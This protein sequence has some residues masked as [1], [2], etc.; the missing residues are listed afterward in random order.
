MPLVV[1]IC[2]LSNGRI[3]ILCIAVGLLVIM[4][5]FKRQQPGKG[6]RAMH[7]SHGPMR[8]FQQ[9][10]TE[11]PQLLPGITPSTPGPVKVIILGYFRTGSTLVG[12]MLQQNPETFY[13]FEPLFTLYERNMVNGTAVQYVNGTRRVAPV[14]GKEIPFVLHTLHSILNCDVGNL[15]LGTLHKFAK[16]S[17]SL[18]KCYKCFPS[19][20]TPNMTC[21]AKLK[22]RCMSSS[23]R[24]I[25]TIRVSMET[26]EVL[27]KQDP[28]VKIIHLLRD[29]R[30]HIHGWLAHSRRERAQLRNV[31]INGVCNRIVN[32]INKMKSLKERYPQ[33]FTELIYEDFIHYPLEVSK[34]LHMFLNVPFNDMLI[35]WLHTVI[36]TGNGSNSVMSIVKNNSVDTAYEWTKM[37]WDTV[38]LVNTHCRDII[39]HGKFP[40]IGSPDEYRRFHPALKSRPVI[41]KSSWIT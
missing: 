4:G 35:D 31:F 7:D 22:A 10:M 5:V 16:Y 39:S 19:S 17:K 9:T 28:D 34:N 20:H 26:I 30:G 1:R 27:M 18:T 14:T 36:S 37:P 6:P 32:D 25:K 29:P 3:R 33:Q 13:M 24:V 11:P 21:L 23:L 15:E 40:L 41:L 38:K 12:E 8:N 2:R